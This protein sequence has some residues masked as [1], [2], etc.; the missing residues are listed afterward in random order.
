M[1][2]PDTFFFCRYTF[3]FM[4]FIEPV[5]DCSR[6]EI[7]DNTSSGEPGHIIST[8]LCLC[9]GLLLFVVQATVRISL[10]FGLGASLICCSA[11]AGNVEWY[12]SFAKAVDRISVDQAKAK[13]AHP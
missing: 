10:C 4:K 3:F 5:T 13:A 12:P 9:C 1:P 8:S 2:I 11:K 7:L 6:K